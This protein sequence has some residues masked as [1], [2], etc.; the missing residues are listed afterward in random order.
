MARKARLT[1]IEEASQ[2][3]P[4]TGGRFGRYC[5]VLVLAGV[6]AM[7]WLSLLTFSP[8]DPPAK[9][10]YP[11]KSPVGNAAGTVGA[12]L[13]YWL[14]YWLGGG[15]YVGLLFVTLAAGIMVFGR[16]I[17]EWPWRITGVVL[18]V[19]ASSAA[20]YLLHR[21]IAQDIA[22][23]STGILGLAMGRFLLGRFSLIGSWVVLG[24][25]L[26]IGLLLTADTLVMRLPHYGKRA[27]AERKNIGQ[28]I[29]ALRMVRPAGTTAGHVAALPRR[30]AAMPG[31][32][33]KSSAPPS[34]RKTPQAHEE[35]DS[36]PDRA[37]KR[38]VASLLP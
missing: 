25:T 3:Q 29:T 32:S 28:A 17:T 8:T 26:C 19:C 36:A 2:S 9:L 33:V 4:A 15:T 22:S 21:T 23:G 7:A 16:R 12:H 34:G 13:A 37:A 24:I 20:V 10:I 31:A 35:N 1:P 38:I 11:P 6:V 14:R 18:L 30:I 5:L 27:W